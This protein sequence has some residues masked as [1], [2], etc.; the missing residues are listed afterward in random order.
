MPPREDRLLLEPGRCGGIKKRFLLGFHKDMEAEIVRNFD[1]VSPAYRARIPAALLLS[2]LC[3]SCKLVT[4]AD[5]D[6]DLDA[7]LDS[8]LDEEFDAPATG[9]EAGGESDG[10]LDLDA[11]LDEAMVSAALDGEAAREQKQGINAASERVS[12]A[13]QGF[14]ARTSDVYRS[15]GLLSRFAKLSSACCA[16]CV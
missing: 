7:M 5:G 10:E 15:R 16:S 9:A 13:R 14:V 1:L 6:F 12:A 4:M 3:I 8:A 2:V 11:M